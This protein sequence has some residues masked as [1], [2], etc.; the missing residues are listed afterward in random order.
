[1]R[2]LSQNIA[3]SRYVAEGLA[4][5]DQVSI[6]G[7]SGRIERIGH[8]LTMVRSGDGLVYLIPNAH[9]MEHVVQKGDAPAQ[10]AGT[11]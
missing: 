2:G 9:F 7:V 11:P 8:A 4:E 10:G 5:G 3:A 1:M 6:A